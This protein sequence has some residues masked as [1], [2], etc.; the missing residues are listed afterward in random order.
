MCHIVPLIWARAYSNLRAL[1]RRWTR[2]E[3]PAD[4][5]ASRVAAH[6][7]MW[8]EGFESRVLPPQQARATWCV[9]RLFQIHSQLPADVWT[10][11]ARRDL[12][13]LIRAAAIVRDGFIYTTEELWWNVSHVTHLRWPPSQWERFMCMSYVCPVCA[14][15]REDSY[16]HFMVTWI[17]PHW[18]GSQY[19]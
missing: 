9:Y 11:N 13:L 1:L 5:Q 18:E 8:L 3:S 10:G 4:T 17:A 7:R 2:R 15:L 14:P 6:E 12:S 16:C 19:I